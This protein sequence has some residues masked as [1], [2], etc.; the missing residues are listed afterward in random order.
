MGRLRCAGSPSLWDDTRVL[1]ARLGDHLL[2]AKRNAG[3]W[4]LGGITGER[5]EALEV[6]ITLDFLPDGQTFTLT[7]FEDGINADRQAMHYTKSPRQVRK[8]DT[9]KVRMVRNGGYAAVIE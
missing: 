5:K 6:E 8:G 4:F 3:R 9:I 7:S 1:S 2:V